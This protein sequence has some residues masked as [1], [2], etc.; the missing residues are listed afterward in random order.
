MI[1]FF[2][3]IWKEEHRM[4][5]KQSVEPQIADLGNGW[6]KTYHLD[7]KLEQG[8]LNDEIDNALSEYASK[9]G[10]KGGNRPDCKLL[11]QD[12]NLDYYPVLIEYKG[13]KDKLAKLNANGI[14]ILKKSNN[15]DDYKTIN[16]YAVNGAI[17]YAKALL[18]Y[19]SYEHVIAIG[20][21]GYEDEGGIL[22]HEIGVYYVSGK[23]FAFGQKA[24]DYTDFSFL[25]KE[26]FDA[27]VEKL[28]S[29]N[30]TQEAH[31][32]AKEERET[33]ITSRLVKLNNDIYKNE[34]GLGESARVY[35]VAASIIANLGIKGKVRP[36]EKS[37]LKCSTEKGNRDGDIMLRKIDTFLSEKNV[38][39]DKKNLIIE[40]FSEKLLTNSNINKPINGETQLKRVFSKVIDDLGLYYKIGLTTDF[41][42][43]LFNEM[44]NW[45]GFTQDKLNDVV[46]TPTYV[47]DLLAR[48][49]RVNMDS[50]VWDFATG[51]AGLLVASM[52]IMMDDAK[53]KIKSPE[54]LQKKIIHIKANQ[55]L[56]LEILPE[57]YM[58]AI[59]N[60]ILMGDGSSNILNRDSLKD[61]EGNYGF[62][63]TNDKFP[64]TAFVLNPPYSASGNG[65][66]FVEK[67]LSMMHSGYAAIII[68][69]SAGSGEGRYIL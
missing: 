47:A 48:L 15:D 20:M 41:T 69:N 4:S 34:H 29:L 16:S 5:K 26:N 62:V 10:G 13:Y 1:S 30:L 8:S 11:L 3:K 37:D 14:P 60:M 42:G 52:N 19:T 46:L 9:S 53:N 55:L 21:T 18:Q 59:L 27:F 22:Q 58:L 51:S 50:Y 63:H 64:A 31:L 65:M 40:S 57:I 43:K 67:A 36:L 32:L 66:V 6:L 54:E 45:L 39:E 17:H 44:Y 38:P 56:G 61:F 68:Q 24:G 25:K 35:L 7:Y 49:A 2:I 33:E 23:N 12:S 28:Q